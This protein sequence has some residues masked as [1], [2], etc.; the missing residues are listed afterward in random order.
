MT[1]IPVHTPT[2][3]GPRRADDRW[4]PRPI[5]ES[6]S[7]KGGG[8]R[9]GE[10]DRT[11]RGGGRVQGGASSLVYN[12]RKREGKRKKGPRL[13][14]DTARQNYESKLRLGGVEMRYEDFFGPKQH[15]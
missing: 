5:V 11:R 7:P 15:S 4:L 9:L 3:Q 12:K 14:R 10:V 1:G 8:T 6:F 2:N 13:A